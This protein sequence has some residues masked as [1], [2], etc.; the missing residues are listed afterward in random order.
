MEQKANIEYPAFFFFDSQ[1]KI[2][3]QDSGISAKQEK[4]VMMLENARKAIN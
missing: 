1:G 2:V 3:Y 4:Y